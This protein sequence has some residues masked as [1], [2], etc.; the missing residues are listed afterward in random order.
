MPLSGSTLGTAYYVIGSDVLG[1]MGHDLIPHP[2]EYDMKEFS[3]DHFGKR[4]L[5]FD[6][7]TMDMLLALDRGEFLLD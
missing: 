2:D 3:K 6:E 4:I 5:R 1:P 7:V